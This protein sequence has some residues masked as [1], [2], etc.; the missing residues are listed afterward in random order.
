MSSTICAII[1]DMNAVIRQQI[2]DA[3]A[4]KNLSQVALARLS[5]VRE[6]YVSKVLRGERV[7]VP[8]EFA[9]MLDAL[10]LE[11]VAVPK[12]TDLSGCL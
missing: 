4:H 1:A 3:L 6:D 9:A 2:K 10:D 8:Q 12:G 7:S 11:L 5:G